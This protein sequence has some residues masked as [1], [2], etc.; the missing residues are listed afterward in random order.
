MNDV[1]LSAVIHFSALARLSRFDVQLLTDDPP[2]PPA[3]LCASAVA[4]ANTSADFTV[5]MYSLIRFCS[6]FPPSA[7]SKSYNSAHGQVELRIAVAHRD[8]IA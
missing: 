8:L 7:M 3:L 5:H 4:N 6:Y 2:T 1:S